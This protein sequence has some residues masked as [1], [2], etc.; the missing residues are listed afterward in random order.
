MGAQKE[1]YA[2]NRLLR[3]ELEVTPEIHAHLR[4]DRPRTP[5]EAR[6]SLPFCAAQILLNRKLELSDFDTL[7]APEV[8]AMMDKIRIIQ[9]PGANGRYDPVPDQR[10]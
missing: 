4:F 3:V 10:P 1:G 5:D 7:G 9:I 8:T 2:Q 6:F